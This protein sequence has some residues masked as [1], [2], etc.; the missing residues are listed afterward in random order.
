MFFVTCNVDVLTRRIVMRII[1]LIIAY[2]GL[3]SSGTCKFIYSLRV[4]IV[5]SLWLPRQKIRGNRC[6]QN[7]CPRLPWT[8]KIHFYTA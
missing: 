4:Q 1:R 2:R 8:K 3:I 6:P 5:K 7:V